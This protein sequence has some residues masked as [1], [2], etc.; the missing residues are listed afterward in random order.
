MM[1]VAAIFDCAALTIGKQMNF[2]PT[3]RQLLAHLRYE[4]L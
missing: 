3:A 1:Q 2:V 4:D